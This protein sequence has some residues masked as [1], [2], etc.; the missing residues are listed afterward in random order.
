MMSPASRPPAP[1]PDVAG[2]KS[3][4]ASMPQAVTVV[5]TLSPQGE[6]VGATLSSVMSLSLDPPMMVCAF[7][8]GSATLACLPE[9]QPFLLHLLAEGQ[10][11]LA[12]AFAGKGGVEKFAQADW[13]AGPFDLPRLANAA[14]VVA[15]R[16]AA[17]HSGGDHV[18]VTGEICAIERPDDVHPLLYFRR[19]LHPTRHLRTPA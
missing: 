12:Y 9:G 17:R 1:A 13:S 4:M 6:P 18:L 14:G 11:A 3:L 15:C 16:V 8:R 7:D 2:F 5:T 10:E 19:A